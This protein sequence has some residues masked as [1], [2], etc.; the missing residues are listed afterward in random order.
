MERAVTGR[1]AD[2]D[3][4]Q[5]KAGG[6]ADKQASAPHQQSSSKRIELIKTGGQSAAKQKENCKTKL[7]AK[8]NEQYPGFARGHPPYY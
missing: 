7:S 3:S 2:P 4:E 1:T 6:Q 5:E 8:E